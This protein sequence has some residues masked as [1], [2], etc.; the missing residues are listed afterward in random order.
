MSLSDDVSM[1]LTASKENPTFSD[2]YIMKRTFLA[3]SILTISTNISADSCLPLYEKKAEEIQKKDGYTERVGGQI[4]INNG[5]LGYWPGIEV[6][7]H[8]DNWAK[9]LVYAIKWGPG[10]FSYSKD[11]PKKEWLDSF[12]KAIKDECKLP[13]DN[14][15]HLR[16]MLSELMEDGSFCPNQ[17]IFDP[18]FFG[19]KGEFKKV[20]KEAIK[21]QR[22]SHYCLDK[23]VK[24]DSD[25]SIKSVDEESLPHKKDRSKDT[26]KQ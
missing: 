18:G 20:L 6:S 21:D 22:F 9:D 17:K 5:Q 16:A 1:G 26:T 8:I 23:A 7:A 10:F 25:R 2:K 19:G 11:D 24:D 3:L 13:H 15:D 14:Y 4:Y 12:R